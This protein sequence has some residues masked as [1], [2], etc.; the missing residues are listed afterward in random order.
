MVLAGGSFRWAR[1]RLIIFDELDDDKRYTQNLS[2]WTSRWQS[3]NYD[4]RSIRYQHMCRNESLARTIVFCAMHMFECQSFENDRVFP[5]YLTLS[6]RI[7]ILN[8]DCSDMNKKVPQ[9]HALLVGGDVWSSNTPCR[10]WDQ[11]Y[12]ESAHNQGY[13]HISGFLTETT[14]PSSVV[15]H[16]GFGHQKSHLRYRPQ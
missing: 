3:V 5:P 1:T 11:Y 2:W 14:N 8:L 6:I 15:C 10:S 4:W 13:D 16:P 12:Q 9:L 7:E